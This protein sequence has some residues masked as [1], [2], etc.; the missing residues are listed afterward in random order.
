MD[1]IHW[2]GENGVPFVIVFTK[3]DKL[4][5]KHLRINTQTF[6]DEMLKTW[7]ELPEIFISSAEKG[8]GKEEILGFVGKNL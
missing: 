2:L 4:N 6:K 3:S 1:F 7:E 5:Q 8:L